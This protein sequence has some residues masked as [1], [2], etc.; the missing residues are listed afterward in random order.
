[1]DITSNPLVNVFINPLKMQI[2]LIATQLIMLPEL[3][4]LKINLV[5]QQ[6][7]LVIINN[8]PNL[9]IL[10]GKSTKDEV[11]VVD[12][13]ENEI[14]NINLQEE[15]SKFNHLFGNIGDKLKSISKETKQAFYEEFQS[16]LKIEIEK[17]NLSVENSDPNY[18][19]A[20]RVLQV[21][22]RSHYYIISLNSK[23]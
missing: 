9:Q 2:E 12:L 15:V 14:S 16:I 20:T 3:K 1:V 19:F 7:A 11:Q 5:N 8:L 21:T 22:F 10:N 4:E 13:D 6:E 23:L 17:I 18:I